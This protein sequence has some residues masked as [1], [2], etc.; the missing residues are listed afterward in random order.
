MLKTSM[1]NNIVWQV[2][3]VCQTDSRLKEVADLRS[4]YR[5]ARQASGARS[6]N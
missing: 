4:N 5:E 1:T 6:L 2:S 3:D